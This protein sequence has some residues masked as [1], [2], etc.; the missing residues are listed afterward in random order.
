MGMFPQQHAHTRDARNI[1]LPLHILQCCNQREQQAGCL[2]CLCL[3]SS[4]SLQTQH[5]IQC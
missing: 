2:A 4:D 3:Q 1:W 5:T